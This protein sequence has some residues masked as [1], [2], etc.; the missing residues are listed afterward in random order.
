MEQACYRHWAGIALAVMVVSG[1]AG[2]GEPVPPEDQVRRLSQE[3]WNA[4]VGGN[5]E[6]VYAMTAP[7]YRAVIDFL[8]FPEGKGR[9]WAIVG[10]DVLRVKC[11]AADSCNVDIELKYRTRMTASPNREPSST[12]YSERW[13]LEDGKWWLYYRR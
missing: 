7:S 11:D 12:G 3:R 10:A 13:V 2:L 1:C 8:R 6:K 4:A 9:V 5:F